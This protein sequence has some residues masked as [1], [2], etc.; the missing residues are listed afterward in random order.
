[1]THD[2]IIETLGQRF[3]IMMVYNAANPSFCKT[4]NKY[5]QSQTIMGKILGKR[6]SKQTIYILMSLY[7][8][9]FNN[10]NLE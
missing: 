3:L 1:M 6:P 4:E 9:K 8:L 2:N 7:F 10:H 5:N